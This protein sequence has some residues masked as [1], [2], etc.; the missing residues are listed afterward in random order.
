MYIVIYW[1]LMFEYVSTLTQLYQIDIYKLYNNLND[2]KS[3]FLLSSVNL[4]MLWFS[5]HFY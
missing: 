2:K 3:V 5:T 1:L 4:T